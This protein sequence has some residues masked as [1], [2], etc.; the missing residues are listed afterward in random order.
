MSDVQHYR[1][2]NGTL[3]ATVVPNATQSSKSSFFTKPDCDIQVG[4][5]CYNEGGNI[6]LHYH[7]PVER[8]STGTVEVLLVLKG[9]CKITLWGD[10]SYLQRFFISTGDLVIFP[11]NSAHALDMVEDTVLFECKTGPY[12]DRKTDK[13]F[14]EL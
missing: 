8:S 2:E 9:K 1:T 11:Q 3:L 6:S 12:T 13:T 10:G 4:L 5:I 14:V 7:N